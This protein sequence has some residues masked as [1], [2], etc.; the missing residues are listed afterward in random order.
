MWYLTNLKKSK[1][2]WLLIKK[3]SNSFQF[4]SE[5]TIKVK[6]CMIKVKE[7]NLIYLPQIKYASHILSYIVLFKKITFWL[8]ELILT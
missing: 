7:N 4:L 1:L 6:E 3:K 5:C 2:A 8:L